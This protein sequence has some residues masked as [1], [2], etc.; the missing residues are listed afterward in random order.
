MKSWKRELT[1]GGTTLAKVKIQRGIYQG[2]VFSPL[3]FVIATMSFNHIFRK[4]TVGYK[5][6][7]LREKIK[8]L[9]H[10]DKLCKNEKELKTRKHIL[11]IYS[12]D[13][14]MEF[15]TEKYSMLIMRR[16]NRQITEETE[17]PNQEKI[18]THGEKETYKYVGK[19]EVDT[20]KQ[21][22]MK[23]IF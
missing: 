3:L 7:K 8:N 22:D 4:C 11:T 19:L 1:V 6:T 9:M 18:R 16:E 23:K 21:T 13:I 2:D 10:K 17:L 15:G 5:H 20:I 14:G 12:Q